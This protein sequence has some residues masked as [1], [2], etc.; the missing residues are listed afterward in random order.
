MSIQWSCVACSRE[1][2]APRA[3]IGKRG[4]CPACGHVQRIVNPDEPPPEPSF[5]AL[6]TEPAQPPT[7]P[8]SHFG[9]PR[10]SKTRG[11]GWPA[12]RE[13]GIFQ[14]SQ[15]QGIACGL[16]ALS[17]ADLFMTFT[18]LRTSPAFFEANPVAQWFFERWNIAGMALFKFSLIGSVIVVSEITERRRRGWGRFVLLI[19][20][21]SAAYAVYKG[22]N[23]Y[24]G[25]EGQPPGSGE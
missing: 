1:Y 5:Y 19:G 13:I 3:L 15:V 14:E 9:P 12:F 22:F 6:A 8:A 10:S 23:L 24:M 11:L 17:A 16:V 20:C 4:R 7:P 25:Y 2:S 21:C 18:L